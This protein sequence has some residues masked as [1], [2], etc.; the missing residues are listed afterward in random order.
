MRGY[1]VK[2]GNRYYAVVYE[3]IDP[4]TGKERRRW[5]PAGTR[6]SEA[7]K[8]VT[9]LVKRH[10]DGDYRAPEKTTLGAY[11]TE[12]WLPAQRSQLKATTFDSY[13]RTIELHVLPTLGNVTL[14]RLGPEDLDALYGR[15]LESGRRNNSGA[16]A[17]L[18]PASVRYVHRILR[19]ALGDAVRKGRL[20]RNPASLADPPKRSTANVR[21]PEMHVWSASQLQTFLGSLVDE[22]FSPAFVLAAH[23]GMRRGEVAGLRW[24]DVDL[25]AKLIHIRQAATVVAYELRIDDVKT[26]NGRRTIDIDG[27]VV[28]ALQAWRRKHAEERHLLG[29][30][31]DDYDLVFARPDGTPTH[32]ELLSRTFERLVAR[33]GLPTIRLHDLRHTH[34]SLLLK[35]GVPIKV[36]SERLGHATPSFTLD[37]YS[38]VLPGMQAEAASVFAELVSGSQ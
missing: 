1:T 30:A 26:S 4:T 16:G 34:A 24:A 28:L 6:K 7:D 35:A 10:N 13:R 23:T 18:S 11:L 20:I 32:P 37:V 14:T 31:Y 12:R 33:S 17:G 15:L 3:G 5:Y 36:V 19:K 25:A 8:L 38:W 21:Q 22:R 27:D 29:G 2:K 9:A